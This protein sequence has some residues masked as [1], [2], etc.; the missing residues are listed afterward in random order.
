[1]LTF[2]ARDAEQRVL[3]YA[4]AGIAKAE[5]ADEIVRFVDYWQR[6]TGTV[7]AE[8]V[9]DSKLTTYAQLVQINPAASTSSPCAA[10][11]ARC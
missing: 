5:Q 6:H 8:L 3:C 10:A 9:F 1:M 4:H 2:L 11:P 7:P